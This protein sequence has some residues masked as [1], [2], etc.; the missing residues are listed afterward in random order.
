MRLW[1]Y[2][3]LVNRQAGISLR[4]HRMHDGSTGFSRFFSYLYLLWLNL[5]YYMFFC[6][7][8][9]RVDEVS[10][11]EEKHLPVKVSE[12]AAARRF[13]AKA[14]RS[15]SGKSLLYKGT[16]HT[17]GKF[18][19]TDGFLE[20]LI[21]FDIISFDLFDTL[22]FRPFSE[23]ADLFYV[24]GERLDYVDFKRIR[25]EAEKQA[26]SKKFAASRTY[27]VT[28]DEI[29]NQ[30]ELVSGINACKGIKTELETE[31][32]LCYANPFMQS[33]YKGLLAAGKRIVITSDMYLPAA[34]LERLLE[35]NGFAGYE[36]LF[37]SCEE[38][39]SKGDGTMFEYVKKTL[40][41]QYSY[42]HV[43]DNP[44]SDIQMAKEH[45]FIPFWY[46]NINRN[47]LMYRTCDMSPVIGGAYRG[48]VD[49]RLY[50]GD[51]VYGR[52]YEYGYVY[53]GL[54][55]V[56]YCNFIH[57]YCKLH[58]IQKILFLSRDGEILRRVYHMMYPD[59]STSYAYLSR[60][61][62]A[63]LSAGYQKYDYIKKMVYHKTGQG[64]SIKSILHAMELEELETGLLNFIPAEYF[65]AGAKAGKVE[66]SRRKGKN[67]VPCLRAEDELTTRNA[68]LLLEYLNANWEQVLSCYEPQRKAAGMWYRQLVNGAESAAVVDIGWA[69]SGAAALREL[70]AKEWHIPC[71]LTG[72]VAGTNTIHNAEPEISETMLLNGRLVSYLYSSR[73]NRELWKKHNPARMYNLYWELL[74]SSDS[75]SFQGFYL[76]EEGEVEL[77][78]RE[79]EK[80][81]EGILE[82]QNGIID[83]A[84]DYIRHFRPYPFL[85]HISGRD[86]YAPMMLAASHQE[87]YLK[88]V[89]KEFE[90]RVS[91]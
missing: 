38:I 90:L 3:M 33:I 87:K 41:R 54:F 86:A 72:I 76:D 35:K 21:R 29:W 81:P 88:Q 11:Y 60:L 39:K 53:G 6:R 1:F 43:G 71:K 68:A 26:R 91:V 45:G 59:E 47:A 9:G 40:G 63:K 7:W 48:L 62:A 16:E 34:F 70:F 79:P 64:C 56:G 5:A 2:H 73:H 52:N 12:S 57:E 36:R 8:I 20:E 49:N 78:F 82:I 55:A 24:V 31:Y 44:K 19:T 14:A 50:C 83:F 80:N 32:N 27:E 84:A 66:Q 58:G 89:Y 4:Y 37:L 46:P 28:L 15:A 61:S 23:P 30:L 18:L 67:C 74:T 10:V 22:M 42:A 85:F 69:G 75:P 65:A 51:R 17:I 77:R 13:I 25:M